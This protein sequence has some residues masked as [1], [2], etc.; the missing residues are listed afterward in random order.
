MRDPNP[1]RGQSSRNIAINSPY[2]KS[3][4]IDQ[5]ADDRHQMR[6]LTIPTQ[7]GYFL[8]GSRGSHHL[9]PL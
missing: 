8:C 3:S 4:P 6:L 2:Q 7:K 9:V 1:N 5:G